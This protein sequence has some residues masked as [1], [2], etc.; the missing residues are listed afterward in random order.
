MKSAF[1]LEAAVSR[2]FLTIR[3]GPGKFAF[4]MGLYW[5]KIAV[6]PF[7]GGHRAY[8]QKCCFEHLLATI[9]VVLL[10]PN[11]K[12]CRCIFAPHLTAEFPTR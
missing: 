9:Y 6:Q 12:S 8:I 7:L 10:Q 1:L 4:M 2:V 3:S 11:I 5:L